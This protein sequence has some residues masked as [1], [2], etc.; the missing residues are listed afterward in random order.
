MEERELDV[1]LELGQSYLLNRQYSEAINKF[2]EALKIN[3]R[4]PELYYHLGLAYEGAGEFEEA[5]KMY[6]NVLEL[7]K[8]NDAAERRL[9]QITSRKTKAPKQPSQPPGG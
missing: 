1:L 3:P 2:K 7:D 6:L 8:N 4:D 5:K 9:R